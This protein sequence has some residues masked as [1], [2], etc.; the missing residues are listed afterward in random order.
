MSNKYQIRAELS[1]GHE[2][3]DRK[4]HR[5]IPL[6][7][8]GDAAGPSPQPWS[9]WYDEILYD[10]VEP[11]YQRMLAYLYVDFRPK[12]KHPHRWC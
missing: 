5:I 9:R 3:V 6:P 1:R 4:R 10:N 8:A 2:A 12:P 11:D 7:R